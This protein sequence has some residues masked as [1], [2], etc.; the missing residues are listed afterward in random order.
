MRCY[1]QSQLIWR[2]KCA[3]GCVTVVILP[4]PPVDWSTTKYHHH[5]HYH[6]RRAPPI[7]GWRQSA[8][9]RQRFLRLDFSRTESTASEYREA[10]AEDSRCSKYGPEEVVKVN[11]VCDISYGSVHSSTKTSTEFSSITTPETSLTSSFLNSNILEQG[12]IFF[13][14]VLWEWTILFSRKAALMPSTGY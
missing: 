13:F 3:S 5:H 8:L 10:W 12:V 4:V 7:I 6:R 2:Q 11:M 9:L 14:S 1:I